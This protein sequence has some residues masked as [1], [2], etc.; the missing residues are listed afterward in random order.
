M[1]ALL[2]GLIA[3]GTDPGWRISPENVI[4]GYECERILRHETGVLAPKRAGYTG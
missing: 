2:F 1:V 4:G 3:V